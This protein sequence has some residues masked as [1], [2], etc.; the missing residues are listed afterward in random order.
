M[1]GIH[2]DWTTTPG[3]ARVRPGPPGSARVRPGHTLV[4]PRAE[5]DHWVDLDDDVVAGSMR[6]ARAIARAQQA[7]YR[8]AKVGL[9]IAGLEVPHA[10]IHVSP[11]DGL[12]DMDFASVGPHPGD[13]AL[14]TEAARIR[15]ALSP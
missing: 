10:H 2:V 11:I 6:V 4:V 5:V 9:L 1:R 8:P 14:A 7:V 3:S 15:A 12:K 13:D